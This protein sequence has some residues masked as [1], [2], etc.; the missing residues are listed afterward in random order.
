MIFCSQVHEA[1]RSLSLVRSVYGV[2]SP[3]YIICVEGQRDQVKDSGVG[4][5][6]KITLL[7]SLLERARGRRL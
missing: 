2:P 3:L 1:L 6:I 5:N 7:N 4:I